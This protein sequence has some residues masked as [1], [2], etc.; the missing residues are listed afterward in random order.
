VGSLP[1]PAASGRDTAF[2]GTGPVTGTVQRASPAVAPITDRETRPKER[3][4]LIRR[5]G[6]CP[7]REAGV[8][9]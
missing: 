3:I 8:A 7:V 1:P 5:R 9:A 4:P 2:S 6:G